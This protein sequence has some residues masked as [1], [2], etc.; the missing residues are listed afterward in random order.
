[1]AINLKKQAPVIQTTALTFQEKL[2]VYNKNYTFVKP[3][4]ISQDTSTKHKIPVTTPRLES[5]TN[6]LCCSVE[7]KT[8]WLAFHIEK[9]HE[10]DL[11]TYLDAF[12]HDDGTL[13][14][15]KVKESPPKIS[16]EEKIA[17][18]RAAMK[19]E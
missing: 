10:L 6:C 9:E 11:E 7:L 19:K 17:A 16:K 5:T 3:Q 18:I 14:P 2:D 1:M 8:E 12:I 15:V 4:K 13:E